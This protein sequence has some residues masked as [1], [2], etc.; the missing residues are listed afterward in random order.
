[1]RHT[2]RAH[3]IY[4]ENTIT[5]VQG[6]LTKPGLNVDEVQ[7]L[8]LQLTLA[9]SAL[10]HYHKA[11]ALEQSV[12]GPELPSRPDSESN[13]GTGNP[14]ISNGEETKEGLSGAGRRLR[15][16]MRTKTLTRQSRTR[17]RT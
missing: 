14:K 17:L 6:R 11:Y 4:L 10:E 8:E 15:N 3:I 2:L 16:R 12:A 13:G 1:M 7:D 9:T 5:S